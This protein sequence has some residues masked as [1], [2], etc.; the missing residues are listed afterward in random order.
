MNRFRF[1]VLLL[2]SCIILSPLTAQLPENHPFIYHTS[3]REDDNIVYKLETSDGYEFEIVEK[4]PLTTEKIGIIS[5]MIDTITGFDTIK[6]KTIR[7][8]NKKDTVE[9]F[10]TLG[11][12][13]YKGIDFIEYLPSGIAF[14][15]TDFLRYD[16][17]IVVNSL[18][19]RLQGQFYTE[20]KLIDLIDRVVARPAEFLSMQDPEFIMGK[21]KMLEEENRLLKQNLL[22]MGNK[23]FFKLVGP[24]D[25]DIIDNVIRWKTADPQ[26]S[27]DDI[28]N[29]A[30]EEGLTYKSKEVQLILI[31]YFNE[32]PE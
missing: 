13:T 28:I 18:R 4:D 21:I 23:K 22:F 14:Y 11:S 16:T 6:V 25:Q 19:I 15:Y 27:A 5:R 29:K 2:F 26:L 24:I 17:N 10:V 20:Q 31:I 7:F 30:K 1:T 32:Y 9:C 3:V 8:V 12:Y